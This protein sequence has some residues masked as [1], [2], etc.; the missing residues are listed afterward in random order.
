MLLKVLRNLFHI[1]FFNLISYAFPVYPLHRAK[2]PYS[3]SLN[4][5][6]SLYI[7]QLFFLLNTQEAWIPPLDLPPIGHIHHLLY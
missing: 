6:G 2:L 5:S 1:Y 4:V 3:C 7:P